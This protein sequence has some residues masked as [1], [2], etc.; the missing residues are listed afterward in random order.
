MTHSHAD[1]KAWATTSGRAK[2]AGSSRRAKSRA[3]ATSRTRTRSARPA[4]KRKRGV[5][6]ARARSR[7]AEAELK[8]YIKAHAPITYTQAFKELG[9][10]FLKR[11]RAEARQ[12]AA[13]GESAD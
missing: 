6:Q 5:S 3:R 12:A 4:K 7:S 11:Y 2:G 9:P 8:R 13:S 10:E 1:F